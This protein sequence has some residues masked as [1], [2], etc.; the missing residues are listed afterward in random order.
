MWWLCGHP[1]WTPRTAVRGQQINSEVT[2]ERELGVLWKGPDMVKLYPVGAVERGVC[3]AA[4]VP[5]GQSRGA[6][7]GLPGR[8]GLFDTDYGGRN[9][10]SRPRRRC[11]AAALGD[12]S[13]KQYVYHRTLAHF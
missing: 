8:A 13:P 10:G 11:G 4:N 7:A 1:T 2:P 6:M 5:A 9:R 3:S 12:V